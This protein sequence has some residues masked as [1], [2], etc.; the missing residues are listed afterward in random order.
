MST[1]ARSAPLRK[2]LVVLV[3]L[4][5]A[6]G[7][8]LTAALLLKPA[9]APSEGMTA[10][11][12][13][14]GKPVEAF[15]LLDQRGETFDQARLRGRWTF[16]FAGYTYC[17]DVCPATLMTMAEAYRQIVAALPDVPVQVALLSVDPQ[18]DT[19]ERLA[20]YLPYFHPDFIG[21]TGAEEQIKRLT[22]AL[23][24]VYQRHEPLPGEAGYLVDHSALL[25]LINPEGQL[26]ALF[27]PPLLPQVIE[28]DFRKIVATHAP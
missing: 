27:R 17:P 1:P 7:G 23:G 12:I 22:R 19:P 16:L 24:L 26:Q 28:A 2:I 6:A 8:A 14:G 13:R 5:A 20:E 3:A 11:Y 9:G 21:L 18:R 25:L 4:L 15:Q 10:T